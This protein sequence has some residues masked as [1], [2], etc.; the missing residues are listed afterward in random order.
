MK[1][2]EKVV[3]FQQPFGLKQGWW[4]SGRITKGGV[5]DIVKS[6]DKTSM[7]KI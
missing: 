5:F 7:T 1:G 2:K 6:T 3:V 4:D